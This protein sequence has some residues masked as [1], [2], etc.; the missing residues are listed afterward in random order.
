MTEIQRQF[1][2]DFPQHE[3]GQLF[4]CLFGSTL[5]PCRFRAEKE[6]GFP[7]SSS[8]KPT[9]GAPNPLVLSV[10]SLSSFI[11]LPICSLLP[12]WLADANQ[13]VVRH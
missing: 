3:R 5:T 10:R 13:V 7:C 8:M 12:D 11:V 2:R 4:S 1:Y 9:H 6:Y